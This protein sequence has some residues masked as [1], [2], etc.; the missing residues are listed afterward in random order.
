M[1]MSQDALSRQPG[2]PIPSGGREAPEA[3]LPEEGSTAVPV[4]ENAPPPQLG[5]RM[6]NKR[7]LI[8]FGV[9][10][11]LLALA[12]RGLNI[13]PRQVSHIISHA[14]LW[15]FL[16]AFVAYYL[17]FPAR[18][19]RWRLLMANAY[20]GAEREAVVRYPLHGLTEILYLSWF[21]NCVV[22]A[23]LGDIYRAYLARNCVG[24]S[25]SKTLGTIVAERMLDLLV[26]FPL[27]LVS[28]AWAFRSRMTSLPPQLRGALVVGLILAVLAIL[29][30]LGL[31]R[32]KNLISG[33]LPPRAAHLFLQL[34]SGA[35]HSL[36]GNIAFP[37]VLTVFAWLMEG[38]RLY[39][40]LAALGLLGGRDLG[41]SAAIF[42]ALGSSVLTT[43]P[44][45]AGGLGMV[46]G[47]LVFALAKVF[48]HDVP[49]ATNVAASVA[50]LDRMISY[51]SLVVI[52]LF[53]YL[54][55]KKTRMEAVPA[56]VDQSGRNVA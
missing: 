46:E 49:N 1:T 54:F 56:V 36:R 52:G 39:F 20:G 15:F 10:L 21:A 5:K 19:E 23:K 7:T 47:F 25:M 34:R 33:L 55:S 42:L 18:G 24:I 9:A 40:V 17:S 12:V 2:G 44:I 50:I 4:E 37:L 41:I 27:L 11:L 45:T 31:W 22:P 35:L 48:L 3:L 29:V 43:L 16:A 26:L 13:N 6:A 32:F 14:N 8:S 38:T 51:V 28:T 53:L 30:L